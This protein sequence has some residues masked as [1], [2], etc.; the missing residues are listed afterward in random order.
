MLAL[1][2]LGRVEVELV[3]EVERE[4]P[5]P[6]SSTLYGVLPVVL[7]LL[8]VAVAWYIS[9][10]A[11]SAATPQPTR[12]QTIA[13]SP[14]SV[15]PT[16]EAPAAADGAV[17]YA[18]NCASCHGKNGEGMGAVFPALAG[19]EKLSDADFVIERV[20]SGVP[21]TAMPAFGSRFSDEEVAAVAS[22]VRSSWGNDYGPVSA[23]QVAA[24]R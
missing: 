3:D 17:L 24:L 4:T 9:V 16:A 10:R 6:P 19:D 8:V 2:Q 5:K 21:G 15:A 20:L 11:E 23:A 22:Y 12:V 7:F 14:A 1:A 18:A 13:R